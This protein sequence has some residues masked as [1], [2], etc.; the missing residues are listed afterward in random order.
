MIL[1][2]L[3][4]MALSAG[5]FFSGSVSA[6]N[7]P[8][9][10]IYGEIKEPPQ[11]IIHAG[12]ITPD[13]KTGTNSIE[14]LDNSVESGG[15][16]IEMDFNWTSDNELVCL[17]DWDSYYSAAIRGES[18]PDLEYFEKLRTSAYDYESPTLDTLIGWMDEN[19]HIKIV[20]DVKED[21]INALK[22]ISTRYPEY[23]KRFV[24]QIYSRDEYAAVEA[25][26][27]E[28]IIYTL[29]RLSAEERYNALSLKEFADKSGKLVAVTTAGDRSFADKIAGLAKTGIPI[30]IHTINDIESM[31]Y[32]KELGVYGFYC[33][34]IP[35]YDG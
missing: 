32:W 28:K 2:I 35:M 26:G 3:G 11:Y 1:G 9:K 5:I 12:G 10:D 33:D 8:Y 6:E 17:H 13:G 27:Y 20:T 34:F 15:L 18:V 25:M 7:A 19:P 31:N 16:W 23:I 22:L 14:A 4:C 30:Y 29:Y 24:P 21:N